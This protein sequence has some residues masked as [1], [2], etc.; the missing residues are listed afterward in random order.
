MKKYDGLYI[1][2][3]SAKDDVLEKQIEKARGEITRLSGKVLDTQ[4]L[5]KRPFARPMHKRDNG[6]Y[7]KVR[8]ELDPAQLQALKGRYHLS[9]DI[10]RVQL[11]AVDARREEVLAKQAEVYKARE[12]A[13]AAAEAAGLIP[14]DDNNNLQEAQA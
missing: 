5:G 10:L 9:E 3:G 11:L 14:A 7:V 1:F 12:A 8:F 13:R 6:V 4:V 2:A